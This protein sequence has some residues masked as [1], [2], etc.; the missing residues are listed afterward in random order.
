MSFWDLLVFVVFTGDAVY[1]SYGCAAGFGPFAVA[2]A[3]LVAF[4]FPAAFFG[5]LYESLEAG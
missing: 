1:C 4:P 2:V 3:G 5:G